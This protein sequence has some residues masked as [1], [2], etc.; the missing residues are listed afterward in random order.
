M[1]ALQLREDKN[2]GRLILQPVLTSRVGGCVFGLIWL[3]GVG[4]VL[5]PLT[6]GGR[7]DW[8]AVMAVVLFAFIPLSGAFMNVLFA[9]TLTIDRGTRVLSS[10]RA[11]LFFPMTT[12]TWTF[13][14]LAKIELQYVENS[15][16]VNVWLVNAVHRNGK[17]LRLNWNGSQREMTDLAEKVSA[18]TGVPV[19][20]TEYALPSALQDILRK[21]APEALDQNEPTE[22]APPPRRTVPPPDPYAP[23]PVAMPW[24]MSPSEPAQTQESAAPITDKTVPLQTV[25]NLPVAALEQ[26]VAQDSLDADARYVLA[27]RFHARGD[28][29]RAV[30]LYRQTVRIDPVNPN[31]HNDLGV[32]LH[33]RGRRAEAEAEYRR[34]VALDPFSCAAHL[35]LALLLRDTKR[36]TE[37]SH[38]FSL[39]RQNARD[40]DERNTAETASSGAKMDPRLSK[41]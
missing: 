22:H 16:A 36:A 28:L 23:P 30:D 5:F 40:V 9:T 18:L 7:V 41:T 6:G 2:T 19:T 27:R 26:R 14:D 25:W 3:A 11:L 1:A 39:A 10:V 17:R 15:S 35:N 37:A 38:E 8:L 4:I 24:E 31:V 21:I 32:A 33:L 34:A 20:R 29:E 13:N 12:T